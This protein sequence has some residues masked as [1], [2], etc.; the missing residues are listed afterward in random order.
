MIVVNTSIAR[1][2]A[3]MRHGWWMIALAACAGPGPVGDDA[4]T[5]GTAGGG[6]L[7]ILRP[8]GVGGEGDD[9]TGQTV[10]AISENGIQYHGGPVM[11]GVVNVYNIWY[12][13]WAGNTAVPILTDLAQNI[14]NTPYFTI[15]RYYDDPAGP[16]SGFVRYGGAIDDA[17]SHGAVL[18]DV[19]VRDVVAR[20]ITSAALPNDPG[21]VYFV[22]T[23]ADVSETSGF[24]SAYCGWHQHA[25]IA[26]TDIKY[27]FVGNAERCLSSCAT[28]TTG[29]NGNAGADAMASVVT[30]EL[31]E[32]VTD[33]DL[34][35]WF[36]G[37]R[38]ENADKCAWS[39]GS[40]Y[41]APNGARANLAIGF[42]D[43]MIQRN[44]VNASGGFCD[45]K[46]PK[47][48]MG[49]FDLH[50]TADRVL[51]FDY[52]GDGRQDLLLYRPGAGAITIAR[53]SGTGGFTPV[54]MVGDDGPGGPN[55]IAAFDLLSPA[56]RVLAFDYN[57]DGAQDL[58]LYRPGAGA[59]VVARSNGDGSF[60]PVYVVGDDGPGAP[61]GIAGYDLL[62]SAD[63]VLAFDYNGDRRQDLLLYRPGAGRVTVARSNGDGSFTAV[64]SSTSGIAQYDLRSSA[65]RV[66]AFDYNGDGQQDLFLY[67]PG[68]ATAWVARSNGNGSFTAVFTS[69]NGIAQYDLR[70]SA[71][72]VFAFDYNGDGLQD[73]FLYRPGAATA[74]VA[75]SNGDG[76]FTAV[77]TSGSGMAQFDLRSSADRALAFDQD[78]DGRQ[79]LLLYRP[80][81]GAVVVAHSNGDGSFT[82]TYVVGDNG[83]A[84]PNGIAGYDLRS[85]LDQV[86]AFDHDGNGR[87]DLLLYGPGTGDA[88][89]ASSIG[90]GAFAR[91]YP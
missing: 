74:W 62:S 61:N 86:L 13:N 17:Y 85:T 65:D 63:Q 89:V 8:R 70:S 6:R 47:I 71:D 31:E 40:E 18:S 22:L 69:I 3:R 67:R 84:A 90:N 72:R 81:A 5:T 21:G 12:G 30:H 80:G 26:G 60:T 52:N 9:R 11:H 41:R 43:F 28:Q 24:C 88:A 37:N 76:S 34:D 39:F 50:S 4:T 14:G 35:A 36:D 32:A 45:M 55:G 78:G 77:F 10:Q 27:S 82:P 73:L 48:G 87:Q 33:P 7:G 56:D 75:R 46:A 91:V 15:N 19:D 49:F 58:F 79:D 54:Y 20:A 44:W 1:G 29:P 25:V 38:K 53:S 51:A 64:F 66:F 59:A 68:A 42:R 57:G 2:I 83:P 16:V 23:S